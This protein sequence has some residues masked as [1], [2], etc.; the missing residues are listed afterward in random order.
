MELISNSLFKVIAYTV[1]V[2]IVRDFHMPN[3]VDIH[4]HI[5][6][7]EQLKNFDHYVQNKT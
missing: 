4:F 6:L 3:I 5:L 2:K 7:T 1:S